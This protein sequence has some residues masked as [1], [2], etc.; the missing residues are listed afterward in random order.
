MLER[1]GA[2]AENGHSSAVGKGGGRLEQRRL[3]DAGRTFDDRDR[4]RPARPAASSRSIAAS[5]RSR[6]STKP[7][8]GT[9]SAASAR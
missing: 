9:P 4:A 2:G 7:K 8:R 3:T 5:S 1:H 6:S